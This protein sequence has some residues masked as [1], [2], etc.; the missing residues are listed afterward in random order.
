LFRIEDLVCSVINWKTDWNTEPGGIQ[1]RCGRKTSQHRPIKVKKIR[2]T[3]LSLYVTFRKR[4]FLDLYTCMS[5]ENKM[6]HVPL[7]KFP[8]AIA[9]VT[10]CYS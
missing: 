2:I 8:H 4:K 5:I 6:A 10:K 9:K 7:L 3:E 1:Q